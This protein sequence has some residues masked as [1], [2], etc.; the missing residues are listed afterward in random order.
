[1]GVAYFIQLDAEDQ[2]LAS[3]V[4]GP[5]LAEASDILNQVA[6]SIGLRALDEFLSGSPDNIEEFDLDPNAGPEEE[7]WFEPAEGIDWFGKMAAHIEANPDAVSDA[8][9]VL[10]DLRNFRNA[11][12]KIANLKA[13]WHLRM[14][15]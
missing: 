10:A 7:I 11:L 1:M 9:A 5:N 15:F 6:M 2:N 13:R 14:D 12:A 8:P 3:T 4:D